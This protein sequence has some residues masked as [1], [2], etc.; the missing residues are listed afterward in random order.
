MAS[1]S[2][3]KKRRV[4]TL[5]IFVASAGKDLDTQIT[6]CWTQRLT[7]FINP[8]IPSI[9]ELIT[10][11]TQESQNSSETPETFSQTTIHKRKAATVTDTFSKQ[12]KRSKR[13]EFQFVANQLSDKLSK[14]NRRSKRREDQVSADKIHDKT[15]K[16]QKRQQQRQVYS[17][18]LNALT[19]AENNAQ[20]TTEANHKTKSDHESTKD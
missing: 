11:R 16:T 1:P 17:K 13:A 2:P 10:T 7:E 14:Q 19:A 5:T 20:E 8:R 9:T 12:N 15:R 6:F 18:V 4:D 3:V